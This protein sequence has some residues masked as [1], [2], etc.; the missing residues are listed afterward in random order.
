M[1]WNY[2]WNT[3]VVQFSYGIVWAVYEFIYFSMILCH[4]MFFN[5]NYCVS[6]TFGH[7]NRMKI[8]AVFL[9]FCFIDSDS[10]CLIYSK[11]KIRN[12]SRQWEVMYHKNNSFYITTFLEIKVK[13]FISWKQKIQWQQNKNRTVGNFCF[14]T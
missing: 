8:T 14:A 10:N 6:L 9:Y 1:A 13:V 5:I 3:K 11:H 7:H 4:I 2:W 12:Y